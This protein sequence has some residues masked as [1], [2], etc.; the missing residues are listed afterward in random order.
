M[1]CVCVYIYIYEALIT[2]CK[3]MHDNEE[4]NYRF[5][6]LILTRNIPWLTL[7]KDNINHEKGITMF[8]LLHQEITH[9]LFISRMK[10]EPWW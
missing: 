7:V 8:H 6:A 9:K 10:S 1:A 3:G 5:I 2:I 4:T